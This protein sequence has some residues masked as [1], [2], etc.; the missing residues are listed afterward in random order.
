MIVLDTNVLSEVMRRR[1]DEAVVAWLDDQT[2]PLWTTSITVLEIC[3]GIERLK[4]ER[5]RAEIRKAFSDAFAALVEPR[6][7]AFDESSARQ[8]AMIF[9]RREYS[10]RPISLA[11][12]QIASIVQCNSALLATRDMHDF[13]GLELQL[14]NP[15]QI[16]SS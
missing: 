9:A 13:D 11:D 3:Y 2:E 15:W 5:R 1:P 16:A 10:G 12:C 4:D 8:A 7:L 14:V 6:V